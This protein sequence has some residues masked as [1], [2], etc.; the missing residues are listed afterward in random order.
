LLTVFSRAVY[1]AD[2]EATR[3]TFFDPPQPDRI[4]GGKGEHI[5]VGRRILGS[6]PSDEDAGDLCREGERRA[7]DGP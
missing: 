7:H 1:A 3:L 4:D 2:S 5:L 6:L